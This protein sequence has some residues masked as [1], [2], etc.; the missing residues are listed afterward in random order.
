MKGYEAVNLCVDCKLPVCILETGGRQPWL[1][2]GKTS[3]THFTFYCFT[4]SKSEL[5]TV[6]M[7]C[8]QVTSRCIWDG[9]SCSNSLKGN[10]KKHSLMTAGIL[11]SNIKK[12]MYLQVSQIIFSFCKFIVPPKNLLNRK[13]V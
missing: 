2:Y 4:S 13:P 1:V 3:T 9:V 7:D 6:L 10:Q 11:I 5:R 8:M 12:K